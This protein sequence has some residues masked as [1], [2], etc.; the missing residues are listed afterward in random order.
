MKQHE[1]MLTENVRLQKTENIRLQEGYHHNLC[2]LQAVQQSHFF[3]NFC[4]GFFE[5][6]IFGTS[7]NSNSRRDT[8]L[9]YTQTLPSVVS[10]A[11]HNFQNERPKGTIVLLQ[12]TGT[13]AYMLP[14]QPRHRAEK[15]RREDYDVL[16]WFAS[17]LATEWAHDFP[18]STHSSWG[19]LWW[20][21]RGPF[22]PQNA[23]SKYELVRLWNAKYVTSCICDNSHIFSTQQTQSYRH[24]YARTGPISYASRLIC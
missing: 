15:R 21:I 4:N 19:M 17:K 16:I 22:S 9:N 1:H 23:V 14:P 10:R 20:D 18:S 12:F 3:D 8:S 11:G 2:R 5:S 7:D 13:I 6:T 24:P